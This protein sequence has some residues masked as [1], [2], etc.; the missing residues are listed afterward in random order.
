[1]LPL[2]ASIYEI[3]RIKDVPSSKRKDKH[4]TKMKELVPTAVNILVESGCP[5]SDMQSLR[6]CVTLCNY[7]PEMIEMEIPQRQ[8]LE[9]GDVDGAVSALT[10]S[11]L[12]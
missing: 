4:A 1:M 11:G 12:S 5:L 8:D 10:R 7:H 6:V 9:E 2:V 3:K